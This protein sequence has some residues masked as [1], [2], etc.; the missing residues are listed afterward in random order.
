VSAEPRRLVAI[1]DP[2]APAARFFAIL[3]RHGVLD[4]HG[5][6]LGSTCLVSLGDHFDYPPA[7]GGRSTTETEV[8]QEGIRIL[9]W[10]AEQ[11]D[12]RAIVLLGNH[13]ASRVI[14]LVGIDD[15]RFAAAR[16]L[17]QEI[18]E[19][20]AAD[21]AGSAPSPAIVSELRREF[22]RL[23]PEIPAPEIAG[24]DFSSYSAAQRSLVQRLLLDGRFRL[25][26][27][28]RLAAH[29]E[30]EVLV[31]HAG[32]TERELDLLE[33]PSAAGP[34]AIAQ[35]LNAFLACAVD[36]VCAA[37]RRG[38]P[39]PLDLSPLH[40]AGTSGIEGGGLLY[41]RP[42]NPGAEVDGGWRFDSARPRRFD[43]R[44]LPKGLVQVCGHTSH[45]RSQSE[46]AP[47]L[48][49]GSA[50]ATAVRLLA[51]RGGCVRYGIWDGQAPPADQ[52]SAA[53][54]LIDSAMHEID[55]DAY[56]VLDLLPA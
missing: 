3:A 18:A 39:R 4:A 2:Q 35:A 22:T 45:A 48:E 12:G 46:L 54:L 29:P 34:V 41:H 14:E 9:S 47:W 27:A 23:F 28:A 19:S 42:A 15:G 52:E 32:V 31:T 38:E 11:P 16:R 21:R 50:G 26:L 7:S 17:S 44:R 30:V 51:V 1:G 33:L 40:V 13:D 36:R 55:P 8:G 5:A 25:A 37:W 56:P 53:L 20:T 10:L 49:E 24:R 6:V 43:P